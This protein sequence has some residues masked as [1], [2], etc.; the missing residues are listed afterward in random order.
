MN[1]DYGVNY[2]NDQNNSFETEKAFYHV[3]IHK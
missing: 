1:K 3:S 2:N